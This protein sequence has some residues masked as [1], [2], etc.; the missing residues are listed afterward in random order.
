MDIDG[1]KE[2]VGLM[3][4]FKQGVLIVALVA[5]MAFGA[6]QATAQEI[7]FVDWS[8]DSAQVHNRIAGI[9]IEHGYGYDVDY[10]FAD[11][12][13]GFQG[14]RRG[15]I[16]IS[17]EMWTDN[18]LE[19]WEEATAK[20]EVLDLGPNFPNAPQGWYVPTYMIEGDAARGIEPV[21]PD[22]R[23]VTDLPKYWELFQDR[24][25]PDKGR[26]YNAPTGWV[27]HDISS[28]KLEGYGLLDTYVGFVPGSQA[29]LDTSIVTAYRR[30]LPWVGYY[31]EPSAIMG[32]YDMTML[33]E[34]EYS[35]TCWD[36]DF[37]CAFP[38]VSV[39]V[40]VNSGLAESAPEVVEFLRKYETTLDETNAFLTY[41]ENDGRGNL[42]R[43]AIWFLEEYEE[44]WTEWVPVSVAQKV[45]SAI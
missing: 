16:D 23:S 27:A 9:I 30:G 7:V 31:W 14:M 45:K 5:L 19:I 29:A 2:L 15:D 38:N 18:I 34:P 20:G 8:W 6:A 10:M 32:Q 41:L 28:A 12:V 25:Q 36:T 42:D 11:T 3:G 37:A 33:E 4:R 26:F 13:P 35:D 21:A 39:R 24:E 17:M 43:A 40:A 1:S 22:L 44:V